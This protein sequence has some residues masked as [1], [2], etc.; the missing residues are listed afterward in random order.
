VRAQ[1][2]IAAMSPISP[3]PQLPDDGMENS[4]IRRPARRDPEGDIMP[5]VALWRAIG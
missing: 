4:G 3:M 2:A 1:F 5:R